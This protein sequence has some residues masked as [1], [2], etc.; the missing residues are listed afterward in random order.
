MLLHSRKTVEDCVVGVLDVE[1]LE[2][3]VDTSLIK[4]LLLLVE[5]A[6]D[7]L[8]LA[9]LSRKLLSGSCDRNLRD[10]SSVLRE[11]LLLV[12]V[13]GVLV[14]FQVNEESSLAGY[15]IE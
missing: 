13:I 14:L 2:L 4:D 10:H 15:D 7:V 6:Q 5:A 12:F 11:F 1:L 9:Q 8:N 3:N